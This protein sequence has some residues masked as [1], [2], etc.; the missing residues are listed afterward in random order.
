MTAPDSGAYWAAVAPQPKRPVTDRVRD[1]HNRAMNPPPP[2][3]PQPAPAQSEA[4]ADMDQ[5][6][7]A[8]NRD[9]IMGIK[10]AGEFVGVD[11]PTGRAG[12]ALTPEQLAALLPH[13]SIGEPPVQGR[14]ISNDEHQWA[15]RH[16]GTQTSLAVPNRYSNPNG[17]SR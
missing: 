4:V 9:E 15:A 10:P 7:Y 11:S 5:A 16:A 12:L 6:T 14:V 17:E 2:E 8:A 13:R 3:P 1:L